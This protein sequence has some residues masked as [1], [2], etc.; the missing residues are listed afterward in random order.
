MHG[1]EPKS[2]AI[3]R[4]LHGFWRE[5]DS[6]VLNDAMNSRVFLNDF[7]GDGARLRVLYGIGQSLLNNTIAS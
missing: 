4:L 1:D 3:A 2:L 5:A 7:D 6:V